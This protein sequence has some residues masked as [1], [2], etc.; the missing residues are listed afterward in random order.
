LYAHDNDGGI[1][2]QS[3]IKYIL[4]I[5]LIAGTIGEAYADDP[6]CHDF[7]VIAGGA[8]LNHQTRVPLEKSLKLAESDQP[9]IRPIVEGIIM[10]AYA[11]PRFETERNRANAISDY[12]DS[13]MLRCLRDG[14]LGL[15]KRAE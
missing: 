6:L 4:A 3:H 2:L 10:N 9:S 11:T 13:I 7:S 12:R 8:M 5:A 15:G 1:K 14:F